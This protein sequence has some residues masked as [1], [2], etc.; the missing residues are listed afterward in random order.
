MIE[1]LTGFQAQD[2]D[3]PYIGLWSRIDGFRIEDLTTLL[4]ER[5]VV[6]A[7]LFR[8]TQHP[9]TAD[10]YRWVRPL[11][12]PMPDRWQKGG[13]GRRTAGVDL[14]ELAEAARGALTGGRTLTRP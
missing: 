5:A 2:P 3:P 1:H 8:G 12:Q 11:L 4:E 13:S 7:T 6:R 14:A 9:V 10:D